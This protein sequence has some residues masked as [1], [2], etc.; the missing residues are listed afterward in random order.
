MWK[1]RVGEGKR[2]GDAGERANRE[3][4]GRTNRL[5]DRDGREGKNI[6]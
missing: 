3:E 6:R 1:G 2:S 4:E 5:R